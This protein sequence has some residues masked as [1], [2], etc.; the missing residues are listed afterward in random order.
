MVNKIMYRKIQNFKRRGFSKADIIR[1][2]GLNK[3][4]VGKY[5]DM[6]EKKYLKYID[7]AKYRNKIYEFLKPDILEIYENNGFQQLEKAAVYDC[8]EEKHGVMPGKER[9]FRYY[10]TYL[11]DTGQLKLNGNRRL[12]RPVEDLPHGQQMQLDFGEF[13]TRSGLKL[14]IFASV[15][16]ASRYKYCALQDKPFTALDLI[17]QL[18][19]CFEFLGGMPE[20]L[21]I[22][23]DS[24]MVVSENNGD[25]IYTKDFKH[26]IDEM[27]LRMYV[28]RKSDPESKGKIENLIKFI[29]RN[30]L[31]L[32]DFKDIEEA[33]KRLF[34]WLSRRANGKISLATYRIPQEEFA[35][36]RKHLKPLR[37]SI[38]R[39]EAST[40][41]DT[42]KVDDLCQISVSS[43]KYPVPDDYRGKKVEIFRTEEKLL[44]YDI[45]TGESIE[46]HDICHIPGTK[47]PHRGRAHQ[48][49]SKLQELKEKLKD[50]FPVAGWNEFVDRNY[51]AYARYFRDQYN[52]ALKKFSD[53][54]QTAVLEEALKFCLENRT[55]TM[56][57]L[58]DTYQYYKKET[59]MTI[60]PPKLRTEPGLRDIPAEKRKISVE[61]RDISEYRAAVNV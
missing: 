60:A 51:E 36:E 15:L 17:N 30:F 37:N 57:N 9:S 11:I 50:L 13:C 38:F 46:E 28:C 39:K 41:R 7:R 25:I 3:R 54:I 34:K 55:Y 23:Q 40:G 27:N 32:R 21:V 1:E 43:C 6:P 26:F 58:C 53:E 42:R 56:S 48:K 44:V 2:T 19:D 35:Q 8:L 52:E 33:K 16:S 4:T 24:V 47:V 29:K 59:E 20:E 5:Y 61:K 12:Y 14:Y 45:R 18:L 31:K 22:D 49:E 10:I